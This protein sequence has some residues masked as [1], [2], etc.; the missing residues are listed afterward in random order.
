MLDLAFVRDHLDVIEQ[1][2][3]HRGISLDLAPFSELDAERRQLITHTERLKAER[4]K[5]SDEIA[6]LKKAGKDASAILAKMK[7]VSDEIKRDDERIVLLDERLKQFLLVIPNIPHASVP[8]GKSAADNVEV[9]RWGAPRKF[10]FAPR[11]HWELGEAAGILDFSAAAKIAGARFAVY[12]G[13]GA[14]LERALANFFLD[15]HTRESGYTEILP[16]FLVNTASLTGVGQLPKFAADMFHIENSDLWLTP[17]GEVE[18]TSLYRDETLDAS[19]LPIKLCA[20][21]ACF[22]SEAGAAGKDTRGI[23]RQHQFQKVELFKFTRP[24]ESYAELES[25]VRDA[26]ALLQR[27][28]LHY[29]VIKLCTADMGFASAKTYDIEVWLPSSAEFMEISSCSN[30][31]TFQARRSG[32]RAKP[33]GGKSEFVHTLN[34]SGLAVGRAWIALVENYQQADGSI[35]IPDVLRPYMGI[36]RIPAGK[37]D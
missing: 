4:N 15:V 17:T 3:R 26:E 22:R 2:A 7:D 21:T 13:W 5:A 11:P 35:V 20:W 33:K 25:L 27:L 32:I 31:E 9:R 18:L 30:C 8:V 14:R 1:M 28:G 19:A 34:G 12:K 23:K 10:D 16:P 29:R 37:K 24:D 6:S 36:D